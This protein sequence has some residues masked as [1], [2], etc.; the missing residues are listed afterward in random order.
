MDT[1][2]VKLSDLDPKQDFRSEDVKN[3]IEESNSSTFAGCISFVCAI[4]RSG[5]AELC[6]GDAWCVSGVGD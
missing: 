6:K 3:V 2:K 1:K 4:K 5:A